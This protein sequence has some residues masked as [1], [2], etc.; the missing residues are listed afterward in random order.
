MKPLSR[1]LSPVACLLLTLGT[2]LFLNTDA[3]GAADFTPDQ[4]AAESAKANALFDRAFQH[5]LDRS[6]EFQTWL[7]IKKDEDK[8]DDR[9]DAHAVEDLSRELGFLAELK[10]TV[11]Y[12]ALD[13]QTRLSYR[14][15]IL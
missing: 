7:G 3:S 1:N 13:R 8:W 15:V 4:I 14:R 5:R 10:R 12:A 6:P 11:N 9:S 2:T